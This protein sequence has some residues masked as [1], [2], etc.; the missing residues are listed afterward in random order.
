MTTSPPPPTSPSP[1]PSPPPADLSTI[2]DLL[3]LSDDLATAG[4]PSEAELGAIAARGFQVV[5]NLALATS[6]GALPDEAAAVARHGME[7][8]HIPIDFSAPDVPSALR[9]FEALRARRDR[10]LFVHC[11]ANKRV[12]AL[13]YAYRI[14][15]GDPGPAQAAHDLN[16]RWEPDEVWRRYIDD[17]VAA[18]RAARAASRL[19]VQTATAWEPIVGYARAVRVGNQVQVSGTTATDDSG[20][21]VGLGDPYAQTVQILKNIRSA[22]ARAGARLEHVVR[23]RIY[24]V[25]IARWAEVG[26]AHGEVF[27]AIRPATSMVEVSRLI[28]PEILVEI[29]ADAIVA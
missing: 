22:L 7:Y 14:V 4:Q 27:A 25:D 20:A 3:V 28:A 18:A 23:T 29:E 5:I 6:P 9:F 13:I 16:R 8:L 1:C 15:E 10:R 11:A 26:R 2:R 21:I 24:V 19:N 17:S 12:S